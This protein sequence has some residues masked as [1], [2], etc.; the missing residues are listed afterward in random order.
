MHLRR[1]LASA[2]AA[3]LLIAVMAPAALAAPRMVLIEN[4]TNYA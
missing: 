3:S 2:M 4:F 1:T